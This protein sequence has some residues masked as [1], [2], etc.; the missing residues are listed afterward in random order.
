MICL[1]AERNPVVLSGIG[2]WVASGGR[3]VPAPV[4]GG[5]MGR[6][7]TGVLCFAVC[8]LLGW[9]VGGSEVNRAALE[10]AVSVAAGV[11]ADCVR[12]AVSGRTIAMAATAAATASA[13][14]HPR[15]RVRG[16]TLGCT[17]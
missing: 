16:R 6:V 10:V 4:T 1:L 14:G 15:G 5:T 17:C 7:L 8:G 12:C 3:D 2:V 9:V 11:G 13:A